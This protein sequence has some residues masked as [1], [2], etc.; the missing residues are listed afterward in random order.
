MA[1]GSYFGWQKITFDRISRHFRYIRNFYIFISRRA[2]GPGTGDIAMLPVRLSRLGFA[3]TQ[4][5][6]DV[7]S[8]NFAGMCTMSWECAV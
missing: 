4:K 5:H 3:R 2:E 1:A 6:I 7:F 8:Q